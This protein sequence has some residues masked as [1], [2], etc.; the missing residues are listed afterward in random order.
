MW[1]GG[2]TN[3]I[4]QGWALCDGQN[5]TP[6]LRDRFVIGASTNRIVGAVGG[7]VSHNHGVSITTERPTDDYFAAPGYNDP[8]RGYVGAAVTAAGHL[9]TVTIQPADHLP[10]YYALA[11]IIKL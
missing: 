8:D 6:D 4:P 1:G 11:F 5:G 7:L 3:A 9:H 10:P 2:S